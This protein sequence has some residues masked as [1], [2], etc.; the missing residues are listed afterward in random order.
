MKKSEK[1]I[2]EHIPD[3]LDYCAVE[4]GLSENTQKNYD[5]YLKNFILWLKKNNKEKEK[6]TGKIISFS[7]KNT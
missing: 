1:P 5:R 7:S 4:K 6:A 3:F 2:K